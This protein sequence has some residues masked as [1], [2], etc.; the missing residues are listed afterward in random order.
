MAENEKIY[1]VVEKDDTLWNIVQMSDYRD[2]IPGAKIQDKVNYICDLNPKITDP[3]LIHPGEKILISGPKP[4]VDKSNT[5]NKATIKTFGLV[6]GNTIFAKW[7]WG[8]TQTKEYKIRWHYFI[9]G[10]EL[11]N[12]T[13]NTVDEHD[14]DASK[15]STFSI[16]D[17]AE[18]ITF[19]VKPIP[20]DK[21]NWEATWSTKK[22]YHFV[23]APSS[24][25]SLEYDPT[26]STELTASYTLD[27]VKDVNATEM[28]FKLLKDNKSWVGTITST[29]RTDRVPAVSAKFTNLVDGSE[30]NV[31]CRGIRDNKK[32]DWSPFSSTIGTRPTASSGFT[33]YRATLDEDNNPR[34]IYLAWG[35]SKTAESYEVRYTTVESYFDTEPDNVQSVK[36]IKN[37][38]TTILNLES[39][40]R[41]Y[42]QVRAVN[43]YGQSDWS[44]T[45]SVVVGKKP[46]AP[47]AW[48]STNTVNAG[49]PLNLYWVH[50][51]T[52]GSNERYA[53][54]ELYENDVKVIIPTISKSQDPE[55]KYKTSVYSYNT[56]HIDEVT[57]I[58]WRVKTAGITQEPGEFSDPPNYVYVYP[59]PEIEPFVVSNEENGNLI[60]ELASLPLYISASTVADG[61]TPIEYYVTVKANGSYD[62]IDNIGNNKS[63]NVGDLVYSRHI[64]VSE[65]EADKSLNLMLTASD[66]DLENGITYTVSCMVSMDTGLTTE[67]SVDFTVAW[68]DELYWP[69]ATINANKETL[70]ASISPFCADNDGGLI[71]GVLLSVYRREPNGTFTEIATDLPNN[72][73]ISVVDPHPSLDYARYRIVAASQSTGAISYY[74]KPG[75]LIGEKSA[76]IQWDEE[77]SE[78]DILNDDEIVQTP[79][80]GSVLKL[81]YNLDVSDN[82]NVDVSHI[83]Y[84]GREHPVAY[85]GTQLGE[86]SSWNLEIEKKDT[87][88]IHTLRRLARWMGNV[89][90][91]EPSGNGYWASITISM[92]AK[93]CEVTIPVSIS[94]T[95]VEG[96]V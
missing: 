88:T 89:Y 75:Y 55:E 18:E 62:T 20:D 59:K 6:G 44:N 60:E 41:Y 1:H 38:F 96:G 46:D 9:G 65:E 39:S 61:Q 49:E 82:Y 52:D 95:R 7:T 51:S 58:K 10:V 30:Y 81:P 5:T 91:R 74:D 45:V 25:P 87:E 32:S 8:K 3:D 57:T 29:I 83:K 15:Y 63:V 80:S 90:I 73:T 16:P 21:A 17:G 85:Y 77:W 11:G 70:T 26:K 14:P 13:T 22:T 66:L 67:K 34:G 28:E 37:A 79:W 53:E 56:S 93:H 12:T 54:I 69:D 40:A 23:K 64:D 84:I 78:F 48:S 2:L 43:S 72:G 50:N 33:E 92:P 68:S 4:T 31:R 42:F 94:I 47:T 76:V 35:T 24:A 86:T 19:Q 71:E 36:D 27:S